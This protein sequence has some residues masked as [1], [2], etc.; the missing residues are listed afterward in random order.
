MKHPVRLLPRALAAARVRVSYRVLAPALCFFRPGSARL[1]PFALRL[2]ETLFDIAEPALQLGYTLGHGVLHVIDLGLRDA[3][4]VLDICSGLRA[5]VCER[6]LEIADLAFRGASY[7]IRMSLRGLA[8]LRELRVGFLPDLC[9]SRLGRLRY[10]TIALLRCRSE[11][12]VRECAES[13]L[14]MSA[15]VRKNAVQRLA[16][17]VVER[18]AAII[19]SGRSG[20]VEEVEK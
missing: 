2:V 14:E 15:R 10:G 8:D 20:K 13:R 6:A 12:L 5:G 3:P 11:Q 4:R 1:V 7:L 17:L 16:G 9:G 18:H 19:R